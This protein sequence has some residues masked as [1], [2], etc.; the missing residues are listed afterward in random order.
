MIIPPL[1]LEARTGPHVKCSRRPIG[2]RMASAD[3]LANERG[4]LSRKG[5]SH[6]DSGGG[7]CVGQQ[8]K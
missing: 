6:G 3:H 7:A 2:K 5:K 4:F 8:W 1:T